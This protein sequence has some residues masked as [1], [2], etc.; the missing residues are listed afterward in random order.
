M[1]LQ[2]WFDESGKGQEPVYLLAG[3]IGSRTMWESFADDW[4]AELDKPPKLP[5]LHVSESQLFKGFSP[6]ERIER[7]FGFV[8]VIEKHKPLG[9]LFVLKHADYR[10]FF[11]VLS[12]HPSITLPERRMMKNPYYHSFL[13]IFHLMLLTQAKKRADTGV[14]EMIEVLFD[15]DIDRK[16]RLKIGFNHFINTLKKRH[17]DFLDLLVNKEPEFRDDKVFTPLQACDLAAWHFRRLLFETVRGNRYNDP[18]WEAL[19]KATEYKMVKYTQEL[20]IDN[21]E[22][23]RKETWRAMGIIA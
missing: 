14:H 11:K 4:Q 15:E 19:H 18:V 21:L 13:W 1:V 9:Q 3:Y 20:M 22:R 23:L 8:K 6:D 17:P 16:D 5:Y 7:T 12:T 2:A 10:E